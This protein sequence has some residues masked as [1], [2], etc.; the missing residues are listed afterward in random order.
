[1][2]THRSDMQSRRKRSGQ[3]RLVLIGGIA[4]GVLPGCGQKQPEPGLPPSL[5]VYPN[6][7]HVAG[8]GYYHAPFRN[9]YVS[10]Y[11]SPQSGRFYYGGQLGPKPY[12]S[13]INLSEPSPEALRALDAATRPV[14]RSGFGSSSYGHSIFS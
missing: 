2:H 1:M 7:H 12:E 13:V 5:Q 8:L 11:N 10:P 4:S 14:R 9:W 3:I 6:D